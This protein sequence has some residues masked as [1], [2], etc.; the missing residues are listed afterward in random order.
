[1][2]KMKER[3]LLVFETHRNKYLLQGAG[4]VLSTSL[5][6]TLCYFNAESY[7]CQ[8][9]SN[10]DELVIESQEGKAKNYCTT[11][12]KKITNFDFSN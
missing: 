12:F 9:S 1:M 7:I 4:I 3:H 8:L 10:I 11:V 2:Q 5:N 6:L